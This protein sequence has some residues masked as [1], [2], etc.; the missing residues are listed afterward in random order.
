MSIFHLLAL[1]ILV[2][3]SYC[4]ETV[5]YLGSN[6]DMACKFPS[7]DNLTHLQW[8]RQSNESP[9]QVLFIYD[10]NKT[11]ITITD[12][13]SFDNDV[14]EFL[15]N[16]LLIFSPKR[17]T[18]WK[19]TCTFTEYSK[20]ETITETVVVKNPIDLKISVDKETVKCSA[21]VEQFNP[22]LRWLDDI[23][24]SIVHPVTQINSTSF[25]KSVR[26]VSNEQNYIYVCLVEVTPT[27]QVSVITGNFVKVEFGSALTMQS[28][29]LDGGKNW[30]VNGIPIVVNSTV[31]PEWKNNVSLDEHGS[32]HVN[33]VTSSGIYTCTPIEDY[34][35]VMVYYV[36]DGKSEIPTQY[37]PTSQPPTSQPPTSQPP[38][39][40]PSELRTL[41]RQYVREYLQESFSQCSVD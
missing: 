33:S 2:V 30:F 22:K 14:F 9:V 6:C 16:A 25:I 19:Y 5:C 20:T 24:Q 1:A 38:T 12:D 34:K 41:V 31:M 13:V 10:G 32:L 40:Q 23:S 18:T 29:A 27:W 7:K 4:A 28:F 37:T 35:T 36:T 11:D 8:T 39:S 21:I 17:I 15:N 26:S 3:E